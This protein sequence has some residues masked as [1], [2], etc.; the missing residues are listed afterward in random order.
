M[1]ARE[2]ASFLLEQPSSAEL[3]KY[4]VF[5]EVTGPGPN[6]CVIALIDD[7]G[8]ASEIGRFGLGPGWTWEEPVPIWKNS[9]L[10]DTMRQG[11][12]ALISKSNFQKIF[13]FT[14]SP[15]P[16]EQDF[17][18]VLMVPLV[19]SA[20]P[21]GLV[22][23]F[24]EEAN[25]AMPSFALDFQLFS[26]LVNIGVQMST[27]HQGPGRPADSA[28]VGL[29]TDRQRDIMTLVSR[30][31]TNKEIAVKLAMT[32]STVKHEVSNVLTALGANSR[33]AAVSLLRSSTVR[34][35]TGTSALSA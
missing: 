32:V 6:G 33:K 2:F 14:R 26:S 10:F 1:S 22:L 15:D 27:Q 7:M 31:L 18:T 16:S 13:G 29:L 23:M 5:S 30:G 17:N 20:G 28:V 35:V 4:I 11:N 25:P 9:Q 3:A 8:K 24:Y 34:D 19:R 21:F 12:P